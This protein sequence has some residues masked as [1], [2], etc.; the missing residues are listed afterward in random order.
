MRRTIARSRRCPGRCG[1]EA[2]AF[3]DVPRRRRGSSRGFR[4]CGIRLASY[5]P[6]G[7]DDALQELLR[8][9]LARRAEEL[10][11]RALLEDPAGVEEAHAVGD[12]AGEAH[13]VRR[14][15]HRHAS[16]RE[17]ADHVENLRD[18]LRVERARD[19]VQE[20]KLRLHREGARDRD[21]LLLAAREPVGVLVPLVREPEALEQAGR[22]RLR[23]GARQPP[24]LARRERHVLEHRHVGEEVERLEDDPDPAAHDVDIDPARGDLLA[25]DD[26]PAGRDRLEQ[27]DATEE[28]RLAG[29]GGADQADDLVLGQHEVDP[30]EHLELAERLVDAL[31]PQRLVAVMRASRPA[32]GAGRA[33]RASP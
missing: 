2:D 25:A 16:R 20:E 33:R 14:D 3:R 12:V 30:A 9:L 5:K 4:S 8:P 31:D 7:G 26:D 28:R 19:L 10:L 18:E 11:R 22:V 23:L 29:P 1:G 13:L 32:G 24:R 17:L 15:Q 6:P 21:A 27:V